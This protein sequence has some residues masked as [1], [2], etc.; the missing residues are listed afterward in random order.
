MK[1]VL[2]PVSCLRTFTDE[3]GPLQ[4]DISASIASDSGADGA[5]PKQSR[6]LVKAVMSPRRTPRVNPGDLMLHI[7]V[8]GFEFDINCRRGWQTFKWLG[9][10]T[11]S[12]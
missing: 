9:F 1:R 7:E 11:R 2:F 8:R 12:R 3:R 6:R 5:D 4:D 10:V